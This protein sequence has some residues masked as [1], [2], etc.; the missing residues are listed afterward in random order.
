MFGVY[1]G[2]QELLSVMRSLQQLTHLKLQSVGGF[3]GCPFT[4]LSS[5]TAGS[6][7]KQL[8]L[9]KIMDT[10]HQQDWQ[11]VFGPR[12]S[13]IPGDRLQKLPRQL[14]QLTSLK[15]TDTILNMTTTNVSCMVNCCPAL[16]QLTLLGALEQDA[17]VGPLLQLLSLTQ[18]H[19]DPED[20]QAAAVAQLT[21]LGGLHIFTEDLS[22]EGLWQLTAQLRQL[23]TFTLQ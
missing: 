16:Q 17:S 13:F 6:Q 10:D 19:V 12:I 15:M 14:Q 23:T 18:L 7:L 8:E 9:N 11:V 3:Y 5:L 1:N 20:A 2:G 4:E 21:G 22:A